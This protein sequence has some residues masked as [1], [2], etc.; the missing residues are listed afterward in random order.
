MAAKQ[1]AGESEAVIEN[2]L[3][4]IRFSNR[5]GVAKSWVLKKYKDDKGNPL[6]LVN[7]IGAPQ[8]GYPLSFFAYDDSLRNKLNQALYIANE[9][10]SE[11]GKA[12]TFEYSDGDVSVVKK[13][14]FGHSYGHRF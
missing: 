9:D 1:A 11:A 12:I 7:S 5:G 3:Y 2:D 4:R 8:F 13:F 6:E 14:T 10:K